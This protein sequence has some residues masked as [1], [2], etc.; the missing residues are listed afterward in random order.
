MPSASAAEIE[1]VCAACASSSSGFV[2]PIADVASG[3]LARAVRGQ[4][5]RLSGAPL[6][7]IPTPTRVIYNVWSLEGSQHAHAFHAWSAAS[8]KK[9][10]EVSE[11]MLQPN[12]KEA[13]HI[14]GEAFSSPSGQGWIEGALETSERMLV[15]KV[16]LKPLAGL[17]RRDICSMNPL[18]AQ[19][20]RE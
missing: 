12:E 20:P 15:L 13:I 9:W 2:G 1:A 11:R 6:A 14:V 17:T 19:Q 16:G 10:W 8:G 4:L 3:A 7:D 5:A 18:A